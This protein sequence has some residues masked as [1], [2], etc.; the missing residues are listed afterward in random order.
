VQRITSE[1]APWIF[2]D[3]AKQNAA[4]VAN[5]KGFVL[6]PSFLLSFKDTYIEE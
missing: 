1:E 6:S 2:I 3:N 4:M 5:V